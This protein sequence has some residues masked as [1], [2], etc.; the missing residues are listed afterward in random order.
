MLGHKQHSFGHM[1]NSDNIIY[2]C[3]YIG[4]GEATPHCVCGGRSHILGDTDGLR[5]CRAIPFT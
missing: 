2:T 3:T 1:C 5:G 4:G